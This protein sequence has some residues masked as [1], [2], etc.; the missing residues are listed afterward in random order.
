MI[1]HHYT[2]ENTWSL[3][4]PLYS[5]PSFFVLFPL[6][7]NF[8]ISMA[9]LQLFPFYAILGII[10]FLCHFGI[11]P[12]L[13]HFGI[14]PFV[15]HFGNSSLSMP[16]WNC[17]ITSKEFTE[18]VPCIGRESNPASRAWQARILPL[19]QQCVGNGEFR[20]EYI[21][22]VL[23]QKTRFFARNVTKALAM[24]CLYCR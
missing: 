20:K 8:P 22:I 23:I 3:F 9:F 10:P 2:N 18:R 12:F 24:Q 15:C 14:D 17:S 21:A 6:S 7:R 1:F 19:N 16:L 4:L 5:L 13:C 11:L